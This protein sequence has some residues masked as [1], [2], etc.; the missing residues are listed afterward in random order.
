MAFWKTLWTFVWFG[1]LTLFAVL[2]M[3]ITIQ[4]G[5]DLLRMLRGLQED[6]VRRHETHE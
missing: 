1:G 2:A 5:R 4:G 6:S 3:I